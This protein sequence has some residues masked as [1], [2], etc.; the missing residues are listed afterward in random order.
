MEAIPK[1]D[2]KSVIKSDISIERTTWIGHKN[3]IYFSSLWPFL[4]APL[5][6]SL[7]LLTPTKNGNFTNSQKGSARSTKKTNIVPHSKLANHPKPLWSL[8]L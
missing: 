4:F 3:N 7:F 1:S 5:L 6:R 2:I 8:H